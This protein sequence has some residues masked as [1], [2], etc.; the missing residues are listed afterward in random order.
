[1]K[2]L[3]GTWDEYTLSNF[4]PKKQ[5][6]NEYEINICFANLKLKNNFCTYTV[7]PCDIKDS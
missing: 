3:L 7:R 2:E 5:P 4:R 6:D 1:M